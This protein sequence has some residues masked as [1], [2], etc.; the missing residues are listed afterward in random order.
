MIP[1]DGNSTSSTAK[2]A[3]W[4]SDDAGTSDRPLV[5]LRLYVAGESPRS[6][7][8]L[9]AVRGLDESA[10]AG[11]YHL[12]VVDVLTH[13]EKAE[14]DRVLATP[15]L[16]RLAPTPRRRILGDLADLEGLVRELGPPPSSNG[17]P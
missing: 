10:L 14:E 7:S 6:L 16:V 17:R 4:M 3:P 8:A 12:E 2:D 11:R 9:R 1:V 15:T 13:P 5:R